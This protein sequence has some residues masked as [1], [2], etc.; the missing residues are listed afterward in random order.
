MLENLKGDIHRLKFDKKTSSIILFVKGVLL[1][2]GFLSVVIYRMAHCCFRKGIRF[3]PSILQRL[4]IFL[5]SV[6]ISYRAEIGS[7]LRIA[8][9]VGV[10]IGDTV[11]IG[12]NAVILQNVT[13]GE[14]SFLTDRAPVIGNNVLIGAG[15]KVLGD[16]RVGDNAKIGVNAVVVQSIPA[17][18]VVMCAPPEIH[19]DLSKTG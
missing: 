1:D 7:G 6:D 13:I 5:T 19:S 18:S 3:I 16:I 14:K 17:G 4:D 8:H 15:A 9:G 12:K 2:N 10:V 11:R